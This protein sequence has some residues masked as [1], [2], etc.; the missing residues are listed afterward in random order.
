MTTT[1]PPSAG[2]GPGNPRAR[3]G[4]SSALWRFGVVGGIGTIVNLGVLQLL[5][6]LLGLPFPVGSAVATEIAILSNYV[7][8]ELWTFHLR[9]LSLRRLAQLNAGALLSLLVTVS[10]ATAANGVLH[11][12][13]AQLLGIGVGSGLNFAI[14]FGWVWRR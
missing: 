6:G 7:G 10:V 8:N 9:K 14:N 4:A 1:T 12:L 5:H 3:R 2:S 11:P 13:L